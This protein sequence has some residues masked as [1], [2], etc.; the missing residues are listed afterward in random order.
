MTSY[1]PHAGM[2]RAPCSVTKGA[3][4]RWHVLCGHCDDS[5]YPSIVSMRRWAPAVHTALWHT[6]RCT[7]PTRSWRP[8]KE[9]A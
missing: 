8:K 3:D 9:P 4:D 1:D 2:E 7:S 5:E 6:K